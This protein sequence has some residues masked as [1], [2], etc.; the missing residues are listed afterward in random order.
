MNISDEEIKKK[1]IEE[2]SSDGRVNASDVKVS[3]LNGLVK[4]TGIVPNYEGKEAASENAWAIQGVSSVKN[5]LIVVYPPKVKIPEDSEI[6]SNVKKALSLNLNVDEEMI[7]VSVN[8]GIVT[9]EGSVDS[10]WKKELVESVISGIS[11]IIDISNKLSIIPT[12]KTSDKEIAEDI[13]GS[14]DRNYE[15][16][17]ED[18]YVKVKDGVVTLSGTLDNWYEYNAAMEA[19]KFTSGVKDINDELKI[20]KI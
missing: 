4:L 5:E 10:L 2:M 16:Q 11:G 6:R 1:I 14:I 8:E 12:K 9:L 18:V 20:G 13:I 15:V 19:A 3:V 7:Q 17:V